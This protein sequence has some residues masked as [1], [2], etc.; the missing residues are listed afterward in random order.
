MYHFSLVDLRAFC[1]VAEEGNLTRAAER[2]HLSASSVC[3]RIKSLESNLGVPLFTRTA[4]GMSVT[5]AGEIVREGSYGVAREINHMLE[6][7]QPYVSRAAGTLRIATN[8][9]AA[10]NFLADGLAQFLHSHSDVTV[11]HQR[12]S[13]REVVAAVAED[14]ADIGLTAYVGEYPGVEFIDYA[15]DD[16]V[17]I[18]SR[19]H[20]LAKLP[21]VD[22][23][24]CL[25]E[26]FVYLNE[27]V[28]MQRFVDEKARE[29]GRKI[30]PKVCVANQPILFQMAAAGVGVGVASRVA[31]EAQA[32]PRACAV[33]LSNVWAKRHIRIAIPTQEKRRIRWALELA[34]TLADQ[35]PEKIKPL[36]G[37]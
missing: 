35:I 33:P 27:S 22:F 37:R 19:E 29:L 23:A 21:S 6:K 36:R 2:I 5:P 3:T 13:S 1:A 4:Q 18:V 11:A 8:Y 7:L 25:S 15:R 31:F 20:A 28:E 24:E 14:R 17:L 30:T 32:N 10:L 34:E 12:C 26:D 16:L 9:A